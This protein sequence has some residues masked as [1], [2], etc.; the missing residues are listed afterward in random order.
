MRIT[1]IDLFIF[2]HAQEN[3]PKE[4]AH[5]PLYPARR[6]QGRRVSEL[7]SLKQADTLYSAPAPDAQRG[8]KGVNRA[9]IIV[10]TPISVRQALLDFNSVSLRF[11]GGLISRMDKRANWGLTGMLLQEEESRNAG[12]RRMAA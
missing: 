8:A 9:G 10:I 2:L 4:G 1:S 6:R 12:Q 5:A 11:N 3:E 7:A